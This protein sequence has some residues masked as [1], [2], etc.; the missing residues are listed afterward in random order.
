MRINLQISEGDGL[1]DYICSSCY[2]LINI[3]YNFKCQVEKADA[4]MRSLVEK[5]VQIESENLIPQPGQNYE[6]DKYHDKSLE[7]SPHFD[8][9]ESS[10][11]AQK[12][13]FSESNITIEHQKLLTEEC[14]NCDEPCKTPEHKYD[15]ESYNSDDDEQ[16]LNEAKIIEEEKPLINRK[17]EKCLK[18]LMVFA[19]L[20]SLE[21]HMMVHEND[22]VPSHQSAGHL[23]SDNEAE[24]EKTKNENCKGTK[25]RTQEKKTD[26]FK[27]AVCSKQFKYQKSFTRHM[28]THPENEDEPSPA[29]VET[30]TNL[31]K[32][33]TSIPSSRKS[34]SEDDI[35]CKNEQC[36]ICGKVFATKRNLKRHLLTHSGLKHKC[37]ICGKNF[38]RGD[39][40]RE[41]EQLKHKEEFFDKSDNEDSDGC[42]NNE[43][44]MGSN[45]KKV[46]A[47]ADIG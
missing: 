18:C 15:M 29:T 45:K 46:S 28:K 31:I 27:C 16:S 9:I 17:K 13:H 32:Q 33:E 2:D 44:K 7:I 30:E 47:F 8:R 24:K 1:P 10:D 20:S 6:K 23:E 42:A 5:N 39:K 38:S 41:H 4:H 12:M 11:I 26:K 36:K 34:D 37:N 14:T 22:G 21:K 40:L 3:S 43:N 19:S 35:F 25:S